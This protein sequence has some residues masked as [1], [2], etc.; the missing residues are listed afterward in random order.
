MKTI[1]GE[2]CFLHHAERALRE[3]KFG[4]L[5]NNLSFRVSIMRA[6]QRTK[7]F[8]KSVFQHPG[9]AW[10]NQ[11]LFAV[12]VYAERAQREDKFIV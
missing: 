9:R 11:F 12:R 8:K 1:C 2:P 6:A 3:D 4:G 5:R 10:S 7:R